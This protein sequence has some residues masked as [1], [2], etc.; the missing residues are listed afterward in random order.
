[1]WVNNKSLNERRSPGETLWQPCL[2]VILLQE[3]IKAISQVLIESGIETKLP[4]QRANDSAIAVQ[5]SLILVRDSMK[6]CKSLGQ[7][8]PMNIVPSQI[9]V[10]G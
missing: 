2:F 3:W 9:H 8:S 7:D 1:M 10:L 6:K 5:G 4:Q